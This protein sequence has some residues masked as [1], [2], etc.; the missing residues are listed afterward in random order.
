MGKY[1]LAKEIVGK[2]GQSHL[3]S[4]YEKMEEEV[5]EQLLEQILKINFEQV[6]ELYQT[7]KNDVP[8]ESANIEPTPYIDKELLSKEE[9]DRY[10]QKGIEEVKKGNFAVVTMAGGQRN[11]IRA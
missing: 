1:E 6:I 9:L 11:K 7:I 4:N 8:H 3:L 10:K 2:Y 5:K